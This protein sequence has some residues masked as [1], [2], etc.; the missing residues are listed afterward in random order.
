MAVEVLEALVIHEAVILGRV[1]DPRTRRL[2]ACT[3]GLSMSDSKNGFVISI[4]CRLSSTTSMNSAFS[5]LKRG[6]TLKPSALKKAFERSR[7]CTGRLK[8]ICLFT[9]PSCHNVG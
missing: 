4:T 8:M 5:L 2:R 7:S 9:M 6:F 3:A 1:R